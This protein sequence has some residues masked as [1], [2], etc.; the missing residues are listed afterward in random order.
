MIIQDSITTSNPA[1]NTSFCNLHTFILCEAK[2]FH[3]LLKTSLVILQHTFNNS[4]KL[5]LVSLPHTF[6]NLLKSTLV[7]LPHIFY[8]LLKPSL[9]KLPH[10]FYNLLQLLQVRIQLS[11]VSYSIDRK[12]NLWSYLLK[13]LKDS[14]QVNVIIRTSA[15]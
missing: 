12:Q 6:Y 14:L 10:T 15:N 1:T 2:L 9:A 13:P 7:R 8:N 5:S 3:R 11:I 4:L